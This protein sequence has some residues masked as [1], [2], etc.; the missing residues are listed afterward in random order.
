MRG[1]LELKIRKTKMDV[2]SIKI[3]N[4]ILL[5]SKS[6]EDKEKRQDGFRD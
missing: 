6:L 5:M 2:K 1:Q 4:S 3:P